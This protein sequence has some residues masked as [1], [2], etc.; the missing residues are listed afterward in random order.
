[1]DQW[2]EKVLIRALRAPVLALDGAAVGAG[3][4]PAGALPSRGAVLLG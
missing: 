1:V 4:C 3:R 2:A